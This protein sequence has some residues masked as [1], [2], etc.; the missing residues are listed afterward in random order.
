MKLID[1]IFLFK[2][3]SV[4]EL[5]VIDVYAFQIVNLCK[6]FKISLS[7]TNYLNNVKVDGI[8]IS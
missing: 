8:Q 7:R 4:I 3:S 2:K 1:A 6:T 5:S